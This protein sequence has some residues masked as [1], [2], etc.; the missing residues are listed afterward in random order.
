MCSTGNKMEL[1]NTLKAYGAIKFGDFVLSSGKKSNYYIDIKKA[2]TEPNVL[3]LIASRIGIAIRQ[4]E[5]N[6]N[7]KFDRIAGIELGGVP[8]AVAVSLELNLPMLI[9]RK[10]EK[11]HGLKDRIIGNLNPRDRVVL[12]EDVVTTGSSALSGVEVIKA[13]GGFI[14]TVISIVDREEGASIALNEKGISLIALIK[15]SEL[16]S[17]H[18]IK[19]SHVLY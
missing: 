5:Q 6:R 1:I 3:K 7:T 16:L 15:A 11:S 8:I 2:S 9:I 19:C 14:D 17:E 12:V 10:A 18:G 13:A 4:I